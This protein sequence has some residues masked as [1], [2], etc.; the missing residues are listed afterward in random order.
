MTGPKTI[1]GF[2][3]CATQADYRP[4]RFYITVRM[5]DMGNNVGGGVS[6]KYFSLYTY[7]VNFEFYQLDLISNSL[8]TSQ[9]INIFHQ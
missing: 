4:L 9:Q 3:D 2:S 1:Q 8:H 6:R 7:L 5:Q